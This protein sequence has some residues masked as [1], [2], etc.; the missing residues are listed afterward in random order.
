MVP[1]AARHRFNP[2]ARLDGWTA[3][4]CCSTSAVKNVYLVDFL[5]EVLDVDPHRPIASRF[6]RYTPLHLAAA[7]GADDTVRLL[8]TRYPDRPDLEPAR[9]DPEPGTYKH[10]P[11]HVHIPKRGQPVHV[12]FTKRVVPAVEQRG[13]D[14]SRPIHM[15]ARA[16]HCSTVTLLLDEYGADGT[17]G[18][19]L[20]QTPFHLSCERLALDVIK[21]LHARGFSTD[22]PD[23]KGVIPFGAAVKAVQAMKVPGW[24]YTTVRS[25]LAV[26]PVL[27]FL[28]EVGL[29][30]GALSENGE[31]GSYYYIINNH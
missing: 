3:L 15:A 21:L 16:G 5:V 10:G 19:N 8:L 30:G 17:V 7:R 11:A 9:R 4:A 1:R 29:D 20:G 13:S 23:S 18:D 27:R 28:Q 6:S 14:G 31:V 25:A 24:R 26:S 2:A 22:Q 12:A